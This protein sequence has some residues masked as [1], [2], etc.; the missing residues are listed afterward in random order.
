MTVPELSDETRL[1]VEDVVNNVKCELVRGTRE[2]EWL[3]GWTAAVTLTLTVVHSGSGAG[4]VAFVVPVHHGIF[5][6][7]FNGGA[8]EKATRQ[9]SINFELNLRDFDRRS[10]NCPAPG[11]K[12]N[13][14]LQGDLGILEW[15]KRV[16]VVVRAEQEKTIGY[17][18][19]FQLVLDA[20]LTPGFKIVPTGAHERTG[21]LK[22]SGSRDNSHKLDIALTPNTAGAK[23]RLE[24]QQLRQLLAPLSSPRLLAR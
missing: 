19:D 22:L 3:R 8:S 1:S 16:A 7:G 11:H 12:S 24:K 6:I 4:E 20:G 9:A 14:M 23:G 17:S 2:E 13:R 10:P 5:S 21:S 18:M 15:V